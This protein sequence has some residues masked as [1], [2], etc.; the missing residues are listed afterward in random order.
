MCL[1]AAYWARLDRITW[2]ASREDAAAGGFDD[3]LIYREVALPVAER[4]LPS[5]QLLRDEGAAVF[6]EWLAKPD[7]V[8][9]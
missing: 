6:G 1:A 9:Y 5:S 7:R 3:E 2:A 8:Q 4:T